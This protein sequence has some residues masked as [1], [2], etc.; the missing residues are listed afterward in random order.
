MERD[1]LR[2]ACHLLDW[3]AQAEPDNKEVHRLRASIYRMRA[4]AET[5]TMA[6]GIFNA[7]AVDSETTAAKNEDPNPEAEN[8]Q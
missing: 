1:E 6:K 8:V 5:S 4:E 7:A 2:L 3:A